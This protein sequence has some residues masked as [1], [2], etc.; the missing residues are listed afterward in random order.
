MKQYVL[1][2][3]VFLSCS[4][5]VNAASIE[6]GKA[7][8][9]KNNCGSCHGAD[10]KTPIAPNYP[11]LAGQ[12]QDYLYFALKSY[13]VERNPQVGRSNAIMASQAKQFTLPQLK[14]MAAYMAS[15]PTDFVVKK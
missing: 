12:H 13:T 3:L 9:E 5:G 1:P 10:L 6:A 14:D 11:K 7:L 2:L 15:L 8:V 4:F